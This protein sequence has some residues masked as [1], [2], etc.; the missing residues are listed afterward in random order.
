MT[1]S[2]TVFAFIVIAISEQKFCACCTAASDS[3]SNL[4][5]LQTKHRQQQAQAAYLRSRA[6]GLAPGVR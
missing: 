5:R 2:T 4:Q 3:Q 1:I 6:L